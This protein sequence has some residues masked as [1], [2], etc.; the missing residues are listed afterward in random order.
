M[1]MESENGGTSF[2]P[3]ISCPGI[4]LVLPTESINKQRAGAGM[5]IPFALVK[6]V[7]TGVRQVNI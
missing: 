6:S 2:F 1:F 3:H 4:G 5:T 7:L